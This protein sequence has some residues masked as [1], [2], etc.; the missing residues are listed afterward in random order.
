[1]AVSSIATAAT[2]SWRNSVE[3]VLEFAEAAAP[4]PESEY[5]TLSFD[6]GGN[7]EAVLDARVE[8]MLADTGAAVDEYEDPSAMIALLLG[9]LEVSQVLL[10]ASQEPDDVFA[11]LGLQGGAL[12]RYEEARIQIGALQDAALGRPEIVPTPLPASLTEKLDE[13]QKLGAD[14]L[15]GIATSTIVWAAVQ[16]VANASAGLAEQ[17]LAPLAEIVKQAL[18]WLK[19][20]AVRV[21]EWVINKLRDLLPDGWSD[22][23]DELFDE[24]KGKLNGAASGV[25]GLVLANTLGR[26]S[27]ETAW[28][29]LTPERST[30]LEPELDESTKDHLV[31][32]GYVTTARTAAD[33]FEV[34]IVPAL[35]AAVNVLPAL[36]AVI[37]ALIISVLGF[38]G[39]QVFDGYRDIREIA[40]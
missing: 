15:V 22:K 19:R 25:V 10:S 38:V 32:I 8:Q 29:N 27:T 1:M 24:V 31:R 28:G 17:Y 33:K 21:I 18:S 23:L 11:E 2:D 30:Q 5:N 12:V 14:E 9:N 20:A 37:A 13:L 34:I 39:Y 36:N 7:T 35:A 40:Q 3:K 16:G 6:E 4:Q 26:N